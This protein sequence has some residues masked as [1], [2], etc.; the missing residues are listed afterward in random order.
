MLDNGLQLKNTHP[1][2][3]IA[4]KKLKIKE[5]HPQLDFVHNTTEDKI[6]NYQS[7]FSL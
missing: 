7:I 1:H 3:T 4:Y 6:G 2:N 5:Q